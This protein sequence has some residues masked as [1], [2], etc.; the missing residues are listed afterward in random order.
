MREVD[1][2]LEK[3]KKNK[4][5]FLIKKHDYIWQIYELINEEDQIRKTWN[6][7]FSEKTGIKGTV[8]L[9]KKT[10]VIVHVSKH[11]YIVSFDHRYAGSLNVILHMTNFYYKCT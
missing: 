7:K 9:R 3:K 1:S 11:Q 10:D 8:A 2:S 6:I 5:I 4:W